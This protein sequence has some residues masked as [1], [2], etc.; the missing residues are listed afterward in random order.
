MNNF[1]P[2]RR[3]W[4][5]ERL[6]CRVKRQWFSQN[7]G[8]PLDRLY[9]IRCLDCINVKVR[10]AGAVRTKAVSL[11]IGVHLDVHKEV[12]G[13]WIAQTEGAK[14]WRHVVTEIFSIFLSL[15]VASSGA[16]QSSDDGA[17]WTLGYGPSGELPS[18][19]MSLTGTF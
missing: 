5:I 9:P 19:A 12:L 15:C 4:R 17:T 13:L 10:D 3:I 11:A 14:L 6:T 7:W 18:V 2:A 16:A 1:L 8:R